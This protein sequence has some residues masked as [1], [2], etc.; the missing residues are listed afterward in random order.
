MLDR[1]LVG[2]VYA[3]VTL[4]YLPTVLFWDPAT[5]GCAGCPDNVFLIS[6][7]PLADHRRAATRWRGSESRCCSPPSSASPSSG[8]ARPALQRR[9]ITPVFAAGAALMLSLAALLVLEL[10]RAPY[11]LI[12][13]VSYATLI[14]FGLVPYLFLAG[15]A[16]AQMLRGGAVGR[17]V[18]DAGRDARP[19]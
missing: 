1:W 16:R 13:D 8:A 12:E 9:A 18:A 19:R 17:L 6:S 4:G 7:N 10:A 5:T 11:G 14:P 3:A 2:A 15:L